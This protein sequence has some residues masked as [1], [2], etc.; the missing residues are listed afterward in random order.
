M[1][2]A[3]TKQDTVGFSVKTDL[4]TAHNTAAAAVS[5][6]R[7]PNRY[8]THCK[9]TCHEALECFLLHGYPE[10]FLEQ[11]QHRNSSQN[12]SGNRGRGGRSSNSGGRGR[13]RVNATSA[14]VSAPASSSTNDHISALISL[15]Q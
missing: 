12:F 14:S 1:R 4:S 8:C 3:D 2:A 11:Q 7:D 9:R 6:S 10:W 13:D 5:R 15:L